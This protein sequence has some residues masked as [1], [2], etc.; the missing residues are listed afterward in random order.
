V[1]KSIK[2]AAKRYR[3]T[4]KERDEETGFSYHKARYYAPWLGIW[5]AADPIGIEAGVN[6]YAYV[7]NNPIKSIDPKGTEDSAP[8]SKNEPGLLTKVGWGLRIAFIMTTHQTPE[9]FGQG[10]VDKAKSV[11]IDPVMTLYGPGGMLDKAAQ[12]AVDRAQG[13][14]KPDDYYVSEEEHAKQLQ[15][16]KHVGGALFPGIGEVTVGIPGPP[17]V[18][19]EA[20]AVGVSTKAVVV[21]P[22]ISKAPVL[23]MAATGGGAGSE[24]V[25]DRIVVGRGSATGK[26]S[27]PDPQGMT[28]KTMAPASAKPDLE[29]FLQSAPKKYPQF[30]GKVREIL[31]ERLGITPSGS[32]GGLTAEGISGARELLQPGG[33]LQILQQPNSAINQTINQLETQIRG[34]LPTAQW[35]DVTVQKTA[36]GLLVTAKKL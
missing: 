12:K 13:I 24:P 29:S 31:V 18:T 22:A 7:R 11:T 21:A 6:F 36:E 34:M 17:L 16:I 20:G 19:A 9:Q 10:M 1:D 8:A 15:A 23:L 4:G 27:I 32:T 5:T 14:Q 28:T 35:G 2:A 3:Y 30:V 33:E 25:P 26:S